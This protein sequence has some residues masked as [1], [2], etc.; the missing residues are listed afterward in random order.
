MIGSHFLCA[1]VE[2]VHI[3]SVLGEVAVPCN[4]SC[5]ERL[6]DVAVSKWSTLPCGAS[7]ALPSERSIV[8]LEP[9]TPWSD[10]DCKPAPFSKSG[11]C[12]LNSFLRAV[13]RLTVLSSSEE[14][15]L[16]CL[17]K[18]GSA[19]IAA[20][21]KGSIACRLPSF[22]RSKWFGCLTSSELRREAGSCRGV[23]GASAQTD[24][25]HGHIDRRLSAG[26]TDP[27]ATVSTDNAWQYTMQLSCD[28]V[29]W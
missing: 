12:K 8:R 19:C 7:L 21:L 18:A 14:W 13:C 23:G 5:V 17:C 26:S 20:V 22:T 29:L 24:V 1:C 11:V 2:I 15:P 28:F 3:K 27:W 9:V 16:V 6:R 10:A 25:C 4:S